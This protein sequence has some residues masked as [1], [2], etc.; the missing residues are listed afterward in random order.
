LEP[1]NEWYALAKI[2]GVKLCQAYRLQHGSDF[3]SV[4]PTNLYGPGDNYHPENSHVAAALI[5]KIHEAKV[6]NEP[7]VTLWGT[8][9]PRRELLH[10]DDCADAVVYLLQHYSG[11]EFV[12]VGTG[13]DIA[14]RELADLIAE[15]V[16]WRGTYEF[17][18][19]KPDG[20]PRKLVDVTFLNS[21]GWES[22]IPL[23][24]GLRMS[25][26]WF[27]ANV[28]APPRR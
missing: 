28:A 20:T 8:G 25:Y 24:D 16:G 1:T 22:K 4:M 5:R 3:I 6:G 21:L 17:D 26:E 2:A 14:I 12:N 10:V 19:S 18:L 9:T 15:V 7:T 23:R 27:L 13:K 11:G